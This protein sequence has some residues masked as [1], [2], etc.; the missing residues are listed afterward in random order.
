M[1]LVKDK[2]FYFSIISIVIPI[3]FQNLISF[4]VNLSDTVMLGLA[5]NSGT[6]LSAASLANQPFFILS[7]F[8]FG[9]SGAGAV[10]GAQ[11]WGRQDLTSIRAIISM[12][13]KI[14][15]AVSLVAAF[16][17][18]LMPEQIMS[19]YSDNAE[20][21]AAGAEYLRVLGYSYFTFGISSTFICSLRS[22]EIVRISV[23]VNLTSFIINIILNWV[24]IFGNLGAPAL[25]IKGA[26][27]ATLIARVSELVFVLLFVLVIDKKLKFRP[28]DF[29]LF[30]KLLFKDLIHHGSPVVIN[31]VMWSLGISVQASILGHI[32]YS[33]GDPVAANSICGVVQQLATIVVFG[34]A[35]AAAVLIG[36]SIGENKNEET[37]LKA[38]TFKVIALIF[39][40]IACGMIILLRDAAVGFYDFSA[41]T[42]ELAKEMLIVV[43]VNVIFISF[44]ATYI[45]GILRG[46]GDTR[47]CLI[48]ELVSLWGA[49]IPLAVFLAFAVNA[50]VPFVLLGMRIDEPLKT[51]LCTI[52]TGG[53]KWIKSVTR[54]K[55]LE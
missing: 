12:I 37:I 20:I 51:V 36:K 30:D 1:K 19:L 34:I 26:A 10:L 42:K 21:I 3:A 22:V 9:I 11:Y 24:L 31:E 35:N 41:E 28:R 48:I 15:S 38:N 50:P 16:F 8:I 45:V 2:K 4:G 7:L 18:L 54:E 13:V 39:G 25:G 40:L 6:L 44:S 27:I 52:R 14:A 17:I 43:A 29:L 33:A 49:S 47:F 55:Q 53:A 32:S 5:D 46:A 23:A